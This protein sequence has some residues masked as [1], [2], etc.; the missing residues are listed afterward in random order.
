MGNWEGRGALMLR[1]CVIGMGPIGNLHSRVYQAAPLAELVAVCDRDPQRMNDAMQ[2]FHVQGYTDAANMLDAL[3][4]DIVSITTGGHEYGSDHFEP[5]MQALQAGCHVL[6]EK[7]IS[8][9]IAEAE[10]MVAVAREKNL[11]YGINLNHRFTQAASLAKKWVTE[12][13]LGHLLFINM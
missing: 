3:K 10:Q 9:E 1:V 11:C 5:T 2:K 6:G 12:G 4:P 8:N 13:R 7:P